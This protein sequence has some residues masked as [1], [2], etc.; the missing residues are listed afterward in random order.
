MF[1]AGR[2]QAR[3]SVNARVDIGSGEPAEETSDEPPLCIQSECDGHRRP[4][5]RR[6]SGEHRNANVPRGA[7]SRDE[8]HERDDTHREHAAG[9][10]VHAV[11]CVRMRGGSDA[12]RGSVGAREGLSV[13]HAEVRGV[14]GGRST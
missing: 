6:R 3:P 12:P 7:E 1:A 4:H 8:G 2:H 9:E 13:E 11:P 10:E 5:P 14:G